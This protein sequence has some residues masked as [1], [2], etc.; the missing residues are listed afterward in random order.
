MIIQSLNLLIDKKEKKIQE[1]NKT[2]NVIK[3][4]IKNI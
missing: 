3:F 2:A 1:T 4:L